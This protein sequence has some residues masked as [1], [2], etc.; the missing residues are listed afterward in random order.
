MIPRTQIHKVRPAQALAM[1]EKGETP[2]LYADSICVIVS[3]GRTWSLIFL[4]LRST[5][6]V[7]NSTPMVCGESEITAKEGMVRKQSNATQIARSIRTSVLCKL[8]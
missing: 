6:L 4:P 5:I 3:L 7:P 1:G 8:M 2:Q